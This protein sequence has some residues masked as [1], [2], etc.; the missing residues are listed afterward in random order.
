MSDPLPHLTPVHVLVDAESTWTG[1]VVGCTMMP[2]V[3]ASD[4]DVEAV[5]RELW[6]ADGEPDEFDTYR[7]ELTAEV[8]VFLTALRKRH[9]GGLHYIV[10]IAGWPCEGH[11]YGCHTVAAERVTPC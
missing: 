2:L 5:A 6:E 10:E 3:S 11:P 1:R 7:A 4:A 9:P 8:R